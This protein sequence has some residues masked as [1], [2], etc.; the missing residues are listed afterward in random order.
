MPVSPS[1]PPKHLEGP[2]PLLT[3]T[4]FRLSLSAPRSPPPGSAHHTLLS[5]SDPSH[6]PWID[7][8]PNTIIRSPDARDDT[9]LRERLSRA[10]MSMP[11]RLPHPHLSPGP[12]WSD[13]MI[14]CLG[15]FISK[16][17]QNKWRD[18]GSFQ[19][20]ADGSVLASAPF[21]AATSPLATFHYWRLS[22]RVRTLLYGD[23]E[24]HTMDIYLPDCKEPK[25]L[26]VFVHGGAWG[27][28]RP[29][30]YRLVARP[31]LDQNWAVAVLGY[32]TYPD[33]TAKQQIQDVEL[34]MQV[35]KKKFPKLSDRGV[36]LI[37]HSSGAHISLL[38]LVV[39]ARSKLQ[40]VQNAIRKGTD[41]VDEDKPIVFDSF[42]GLAGPYD[43]SHHF[44]FEAARGVEELSPMKAACGHS[45]H[46]FRE[47]S[48]A[49]RL[50]QMLCSLDEC[51]RRS[52][53]N[54]L[55]KILLLHG[56]EDSTVP[57]TATGEA[58]KVLRSCGV[59]KCQEVYIAQTGH[60][61]I[62]MQLMLC[63]QASRIVFDWLLTMDDTAR[64]T[65]SKLTISPMRHARSK[66]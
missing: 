9:Q 34:A 59:S 10:H 51:E 19:R 60:Q 16:Q 27:S 7:P 25:R 17:T 65:N 13:R 63:G 62:V 58:A 48:P 32:R 57:F 36:T 41:T 24:R 66:L 45:I 28:G 50:K 11:N 40:T 47:H 49:L 64:P 39:Q 22:K 44:D 43:I 37:G 26:V 2:N 53:D 21:L 38:M 55:P 1:K 30:M 12:E 33:A 15:V 35:F 52:M 23:H 42:I 20:V 56:I 4:A 31:F 46:N 6:Q 29:W 61:D 5:G 18:N 14:R 54:F 3:K 8:H